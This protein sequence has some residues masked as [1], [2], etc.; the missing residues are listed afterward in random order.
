MLTAPSYQPSHPTACKHIAI[1][2]STIFISSPRSPAKGL[3]GY[4]AQY[5]PL[6]SN[7]AF[8][9]VVS[10]EVPASSLPVHVVLDQALS[11]A[12]EKK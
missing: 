12:E 11:F 8:P 9:S 2:I 3:E 1:L 6:W 4:W 7:A 5:V 10:S